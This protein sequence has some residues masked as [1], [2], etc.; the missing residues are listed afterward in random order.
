M[1][2]NGR[3]SPPGPNSWRSGV[4]PLPYPAEPRRRLQGSGLAA[5][6]PDDNLSGNLLN[7][8]SGRAR[9]YVVWPPS[10]TIAAPTTK[11]AASEQSQRTVAAISSGVPI[12]PIGSC[13]ITA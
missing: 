6:D 13:A 3:H 1:R 9:N 11:L 2:K 7:A 10:T 8:M 5:A 4:V 12:R